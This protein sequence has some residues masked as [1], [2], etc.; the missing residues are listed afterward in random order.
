MARRDGRSGWRGPT[1]HEVAELAGVGPA[2]VDRVLNNR[3]NVREATRQRVRAAYDKLRL[4]I[5]QAEPL[6]VA[7]FCESGASFNAT[8][9]AAVQTVHRTL[10]G[11]DIRGSYALTNVLDPQV[12]ASGLLE[13]GKTAGGALVVAREH[14]AINGAIRQ[15]RRAGKPVVCLTTDLPSSRRNTYVGN[16]QHAAG[17]VAAQLIGHALSRKDQRILLVMSAAFRCQKERELGFR[18]V[19]RTVFPHLRIEERVISDDVP[20]STQAQLTGHFDTH[21]VPQA[22]YNVAGAN[23]GVAWALEQTGRAQSVIFVGHE[24]TPVSQ[25]LLTSGTMD[26]VVSHDFVAELSQAVRWIEDFYKGVTSDP[27]PSP[28]LLHTRYNCGL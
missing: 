19:L 6:Q 14:P 21:G 4:E 7:L 9:D 25:Q 13:A 16:D 12:F 5:T 1:I 17:S 23:R 3:P 18:R 22:I 28:I 10:A 11:V 27:P 26:Y 15:L 24:L 20:A 8:M 2:T